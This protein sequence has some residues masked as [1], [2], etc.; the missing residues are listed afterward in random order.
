MENK[1]KRKTKVLTKTLVMAVAVLA[2]VVVGTGGTLAY[3]TSA[4]LANNMFSVGNVDVEPVEEFDPPEELIP[5]VS[6]KK[7]VKIQNNGRC[8][9]YVRVKAVFTDG[10]ME[11][12]CTV[13]WNTTDFTYNSSDGY[14]YHKAIVPVDTMTNSLFTTVTVSSDASQTEL[15]EFDIIIYAEAYQSDKFATYTEAWSNFSKNEP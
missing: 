3:L 7:D 10:D 5:G 13:D 12:L 9:C 2:V 4:D 11:K 6:F 8:D 15:K 1:Q 14:W